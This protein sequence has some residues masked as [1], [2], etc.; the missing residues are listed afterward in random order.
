MKT[1]PQ[2]TFDMTVYPSHWPKRHNACTE[3]CDMLEGPCACGAWHN[4]D[5]GWARS[6]ATRYGVTN[7][8]TDD[9]LRRVFGRPDAL[10]TLR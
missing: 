5:E 9:N 2:R 6:M 3:P 4:K 8:R 10:N 7:T 1:M